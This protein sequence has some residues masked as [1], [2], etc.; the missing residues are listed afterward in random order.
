MNRRRAAFR[1]TLAALTLCFSGTGI[2]A[3]ETDAVT[4]AS[5]STGH[6]YR[7]AWPARHDQQ[8]ERMTRWADELGL[9]AQQRSDLQI[10]TSDYATRFRDLAKLGRDS[11]SELM[12]MA[13]DDPAYRDQTQD[14]SAL[15]ASSAAELV[16]LLAEMR[17]KLYSVLTA[18]QRETFHE[19]LQSHRDQK[20]QDSG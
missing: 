7:A 13:P 4:G 12:Q 18:E 10:I 20:E 19:K 9:T 2:S 6:D 3:S 5:P 15:A 17:G 8:S 1:L 14:A 16:T 11:A